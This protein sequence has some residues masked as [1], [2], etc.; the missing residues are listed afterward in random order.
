MGLLSYDGA[1]LGNTHSSKK[2]LADEKM[3]LHPDAFDN[4]ILSFSI[5]TKRNS[6]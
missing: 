1:D 6:T 3:G 5:T 2:F 4:S